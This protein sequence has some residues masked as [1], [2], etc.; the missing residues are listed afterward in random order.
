M[1]NQLFI[2][3]TVIKQFILKDTFK[4]LFSDAFFINTLFKIDL[5]FH[6]FNLKV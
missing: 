2:N 3:V 4:T 6:Y 5:F 1:I